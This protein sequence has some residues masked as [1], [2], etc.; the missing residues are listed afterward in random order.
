MNY[1][2][3]CPIC[4]KSYLVRDIE[5]HVNNCLDATA[6]DAQIKNDEDLA[7]Q[8]N[9]KLNLVLTFNKFADSN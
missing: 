2:V 1:S 6:R 4:N 9:N 7:L 8:L 3:P 5:Q